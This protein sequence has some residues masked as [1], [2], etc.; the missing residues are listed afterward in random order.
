MDFEYRSSV[1]ISVPF[2][3]INNIQQTFAHPQV[4]ARQMVT[5]VEASYD[6]PFYDKVEGLTCTRPVAPSSGE[7]QA[8]VTGGDIQREED[9]RSKTTPLSVPAHH[10]GSFANLVDHLLQLTGVAKNRSSRSW[11]IAAKR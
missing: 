9:A 2:G 10:R 6:P 1:S 8:R 5:E 4:A 3:P 7:D 11:A